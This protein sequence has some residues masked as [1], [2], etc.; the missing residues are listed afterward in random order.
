MHV[1]PSKTVEFLTPPFG[2][3]LVLFLYGPIPQYADYHRFADTRTFLGLPNFSDTASN[4]PFLLI[5]I[6]G[7]AHWVVQPARERSLA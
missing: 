1:A 6:A 5:G 7:I 4:I 2:V 3:A